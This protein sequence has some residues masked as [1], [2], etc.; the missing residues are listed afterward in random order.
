MVTQETLEKRNLP[1]SNYK[2]IIPDEVERKIRFLCNKIWN[3]E[4]SGVLFFTYEGSF[5][6]DDLAIICKD[7][8]LMDIGNAS[9]T[10]FNMSPDVVGYMTDNDLLDY[11]TG[12]I[13]SHHS[14]QAFF[15]GTDISTLKEEGLERN[16]FVSLVVNNQGNYVAAIT[17]KAIVNKTITS[18]NKYSFFDKG[19]IEGNT[20]ETK[21][22]EVVQYFDLKIVK[23]S[24]NFTDLEDRI[25]ELQKRKESKVTPI[26][27][28]LPF[29]DYSKVPYQAKE[30]SSKIEVDDT[31]LQSISE[32]ED[33]EKL[34]NP[35]IVNLAVKQLIT[36]NNLITEDSKI[37]ISTWAKSMPAIYQKRFG[38]DKVGMKRFEYWAETHIDYILDGIEDDELMD[39]GCFI[40]D[41]PV[42]YAAAIKK[43]LLKLPSNEYLKVYIK[44]LGRY[45]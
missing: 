26:M 31:E 14:M 44:T 30:T 13:H 45:E 42:I 5:E 29:K 9:S 32:I 35:L 2:L 4:W 17:R 36:C 15:S 28:T 25:K 3:I 8:Y 24:Y 34:A 12:L 1:S 20:Q 27:G 11:Q 23:E 33:F 18:N 38:N 10:E 37:T 41:I 43:E 6:T 22:E 40:D 19:I 39:R 21:T 7:I 16:N